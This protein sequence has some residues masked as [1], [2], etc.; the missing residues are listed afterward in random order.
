M[1]KAGGQMPVSARGHLAASACAPAALRGSERG[2]D[3]PRGQRAVE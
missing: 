1:G 3:R 2:A